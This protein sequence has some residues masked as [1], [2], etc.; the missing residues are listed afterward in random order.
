MGHP[1][2]FILNNIVSSFTLPVSLSSQKHFSCNDC[3]INKS[4]KLP[5]SHSSITS[6]KPFQ[7][8]FSDV[9]T[10]PILSSDNYKYYLVVIDH[11]TR[12]SWMFPLK[13]KS[14]VKDT[15][16]AFKNLVENFFQTKILTFYSDN[17]GEFVALRSYFQAHGISHY[18]SPPHTPEHNGI[19]ER[20]HRHVVETVMS[21]LS[22]ASVPKQYW[23][24]AFAVAIYL[25]NRMPT[26]NLEMQSPFQKLF[27][28]SP[29]YTK[30]QIFGCACYPWL[31]PYTRHKLKDRSKRCVFFGYSAT[32]SA[33]LCYDSD[34]DRLYVSRHVQF[35][36]S[37]FPFSTRQTQSSSSKVPTEPP[38]YAWPPV[39]PI[40]SVLPH[41][42]PSDPHQNS[43]PTTAQ[44]TATPTPQVS[45]S[46]S[47]STSA[48][49]SSE[50][51]V[52]T[53]NGPQPTAQIPQH[54][55]T[56]LNPTPAN[57]MAQTIPENTQT[58]TSPNPQKETSHNSAQSSHQ[59]P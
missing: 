33:F 7:Y 11:F 46:N 6:T 49:P 43:T 47:I 25:I 36:E 12:Y 20:K 16:I 31:K 17:G 2:T 50:P 44:L 53:Q 40:L 15:I 52:P 54:T 10:S 48:S 18:I 26:Q 1:S 32:Q 42:P 4:H 41:R 45:S 55:Q 9:W 57:S 58:H 5:F 56:Q 27:G 8:I 51:T 28:K 19:S 13:Q 34:N 35:D 14:H 3:L 23:P 38:P 30:L 22:K 29:N 24:F 21:L 37:S 39:S 59:I